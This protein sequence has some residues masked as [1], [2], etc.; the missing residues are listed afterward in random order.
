MRTTLNINDSL[1]KAIGKHTGIT[2]KT[3]I[4]NTALAEWLGKLRRDNLINA[5]GKID[6]DLDVREFRNRDL[7]ELKELYG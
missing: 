4:I 2:N 3:E 7:T 5:Y 1:I 6:I